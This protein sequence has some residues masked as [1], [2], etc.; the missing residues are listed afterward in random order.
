[1]LRY[2]HSLFSVLAIILLAN[3]CS[4]PKSWQYDDA[5]WVGSHHIADRTN[6]YPWILKKGDI[7]CYL[8]NHLGQ[9]MDSCT[10]TN[11]VKGDT[12]RMV[13]HPF[14]VIFQDEMKLN[15]YQ[16][17]D[18]INFPYVKGNK[19]WKYRAQLVRAMRTDNLHKDNVSRLLI[20][21]TFS[22]VVADEN[23]ND[24]LTVFQYLTFGEDSIE[25]RFDYMYN[26]KL[27]YAEYNIQPYHLSQIDQ[28]LF[29]SCQ[30]NIENPQPIMQILEASKNELTIRSFF[31]G[32]E[33]INT[34]SIMEKPKSAAIHYSNCYDGH[35]GE[36]YHNSIDV[37]YKQGND[38]LIKK[39]SQNAPVDVGNGYIIVQFNI[40]CLGR[41]GRPGIITMDTKYQKRSFSD[42]LI[43]HILNHVMRLRDW[44]PSVSDADYFAYK[45]V[46]AFLMFKIE[47]GKITDLC[48]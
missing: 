15:L 38:F 22:A 1:M 8:I 32:K 21:K 10:A 12:L 3:S 40:N 48:P 37:T 28:S 33:T 14:E 6:A 47:N 5:I 18:T 7:K 34:Y 43:Y 35:I 41:C 36:Y 2:N 25:A 16:L 46:H 19:N 17:N 9:K 45:D 26:D 27:M 29:L 30:S 4:H 20:G 42:A 11:I 23:P 24:Q 44:P 31:N 39:V 13:N